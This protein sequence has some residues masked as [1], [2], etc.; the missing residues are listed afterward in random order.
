MS[1][2]YDHEQAKNQGRNQF[3]ITGNEA[4]DA[5]FELLELIAAHSITKDHAAE[6]MGLD[7]KT[8]AAWVDGTDK[9]TGPSDNSLE[10]LK[11][12]LNEDR[13]RRSR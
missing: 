2:S 13:H 1:Q 8:V 10:R 12:A 11:L 6:L 4:S 9:I 7:L 3:G 5:R